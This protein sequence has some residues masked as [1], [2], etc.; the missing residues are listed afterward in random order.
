MAGFLNDRGARV[1]V[2]VHPVSEAH[3]H[4]GIT[5]V[6]DP[7]EIG[8]DVLLVADLGEHLQHRFVGAAM[9]GPPK[10]G[11]A[12]GDAG[13]GVGAGR[14][15]QTHGR[16]R[17]VLLV[18][19]VENENPVHGIGHD[20]I[21]LV[22]LA[23]HREHHVEEVLGILQIVTWI[24]ERLADGEFVRHR[25]D[26]RHLRDQA[27]GRHHALVG[28]G[29]VGA[30]VIEGGQGPDDTTHDRHGMG[31]A[32]E[33]PVEEVELLMHHGVVSD[34]VLEL[35]LLRRRRKLAEQQ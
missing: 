14:R 18:V 21:D 10:R 25:R 19:G 4:G 24:D 26:R 28:V 34:V 22:S 5:L 35:F 1:V 32:A 20:R 8:R 6:F 30:V 9:G 33:P 15:R 16:G 7:I 17:G 3:Q 31:V 23:G 13:E 2:L 29:D 27:I 12:G 11:D